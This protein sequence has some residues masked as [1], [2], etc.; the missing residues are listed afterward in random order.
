MQ[1]FHVIGMFRCVG[2]QG[3]MVY[4][5]YGG[6]S[7]ESLTHKSLGQFNNRKKSLGHFNRASHFLKSSNGY[8]EQVPF[9]VPFSL[10][11]SQSFPLCALCIAVGSDAHALG[12]KAPCLCCK[13]KNKH[14]A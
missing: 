14:M 1:Q 2:I 4:L 10:I 13:K 12:L 9:K 6:V 8:V 3:G 7:K 11:S 5:F